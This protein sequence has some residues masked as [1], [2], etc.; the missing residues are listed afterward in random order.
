MKS[1]DI[2]SLFEAQQEL[3][4][5]AMNPS[6]LKK[7]AAAIPGVQVGM[8]FEMVVPD[9][10][11]EE[12]EGE[13]EPDYGRDER[14]ADID[15]I[16]RFFG[17][18]D[19]YVGN[20]NS[21]RQLDRL[22]D[23]LYEKFYEW[24]SEKIDEDWNNDGKEFFIDW[25]KKNVDPD[26]VADHVDK[27]EDL[28]GNRNPD[29]SDY[30]EFIEAAW[31]N[32]F[33]DDNYQ[34]A[35]DEFREE[36]Q[37]EGDFD[38]ETF[39]RDIGI[40]D[41]SDVANRVSVD[42]SWPY[43]ESSYGGGG[44]EDV[45]SI[46]NDFSDAIGKPVYTS[47][48]YHGARR[49][50]GAYS[51]EPDGSIDASSGEAGLE[52]I[53]PPMDVDE[54]I[55]DLKKVKEWADD[56]GCY[57]NRSTGLH[58]NVSIPDYSLDKLDYVKLAVL[59][60]D[61]YI[62]E[63]F[64]RLSNSYAKSALD[65]IKE[66]AKNNEEVD[67]LLKQLKGNVETIASKILH[68][69]RT[70]KFTSINTKDKYVEFRSA[71]G[72]WLGK[73][74]DK[75]EN[76][77][78]RNIVALDA[79]C[80]PTKYKKEYQK[81]LYK[82]LK[83]KDEKSD[84][85]Y[86]ARYMSGEI[87][88]SDYMQVLEKSR[89][90][91][92]R[93]QGIRILKPSELEENDWVITYDDDKTK[94]E[95]IYIANTDKVPTEEAAFNAAK[96][97]KPQ[98]FKPN[99]IDYITVKP[100]KFDEAL[101]DLKLYRADYSYKT[102]AVV[103][104]DEEQAREFIRI[105]DP[106]FFAANP[107]EKI[108]VTDE[109]VSSMRK[110]KEM[111]DWVQDKLEKGRAWNAR[112]KIWMARGRASEPAFSNRYYI[113][114]VTRDDAIAVLNQ[115]DPGYRIEDLYVTEEYPS[116]SNYEAYKTAQEDLIRQYEA[117]R[118]QRQAA[119][120]ETIDISNLKGYRVSNST[121]YMYVVAENGGE[122][123][124]IA[125]KIDPERFPN[126]A[127]ITVQDAGSIGADT[128]IRGM[129]ARQQSLLG[130]QQPSAPKFEVNDRVK[131]VGQFPSLIGELGTVLQVSPNYDF[132]SVQIDGNSSPSSFPNIALK[133][134]E[135]STPRM[136]PGEQMYLVTNTDTGHEVRLAADSGATAVYRA[137][138]NDPQ[139][140]PGGNSN[141]NITVTE[142]RT[143][144]PAAPQ[145]ATREFYVGNNRLGGTV[146]VS[147]PDEAEAYHAA[148]RARPEW[149]IRDLSVTEVGGDSNQSPS[150]T[151]ISD[152]RYYRVQRQDAS[153]RADVAAA[154]P[155]DAMNRVRQQNPTWRDSPLTAELL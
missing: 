154:S 67:K 95:T 46:G 112:P 52:F 40:R 119:E 88:R 120:D 16:V 33:D 149:S 111:N 130:N 141:T 147:A 125:S 145:T 48:S 137:T 103:A 56:R 144:P 7:L 123:A 27:E 9:A 39:L 30:M 79:A 109:N 146:L 108:D 98:W 126:I 44:G 50:P 77:V 64:G 36:K 118:I 132:V 23:D 72:D 29:G 31:E 10:E 86:F 139:N 21:E 57:T 60:G 152:L 24:Q 131:V 43:Y 127:D 106:E 22:R 100:Y 25:V 153:G 116:D 92:F 104:K 101:K 138:R 73:N 128:L 74:F 155:E 35:Y 151:R 20:N 90:D 84:M 93:E 82:L 91:R 47:T 97:F 34:N 5:V 83:P 54:M 124:E 1:T 87:N 18:E 71:G 65:V 96:K 136:A 110:I 135:D 3:F 80:D 49:E 38:E 114:A 99:T 102:T 15:D 94:Q 76:T 133:K 143:P 122:A 81:A 69:G 68:S 62:L 11:G 59:L 105:M 78:L 45:E 113:S 70:D 61:K 53:S 32:G 51:L 121:T 55:D 117:E 134:V 58:I 140:F 107:D 28:F 37:N 142:L 13:L 66:R 2:Y 150:N 42:I 41:M 129:Y 85:S 26:D 115:L 89:T 12:D 14:A 8:E 75:I 63:Q 6:N 19:D 4:E 17:E 148:T